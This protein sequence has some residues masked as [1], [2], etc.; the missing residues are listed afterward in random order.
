MKK[1]VVST[2][3]SEIKIFIVFMFLFTQNLHENNQ[4]RVFSCILK[5]IQLYFYAK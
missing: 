1:K 4:F 5:K 3:Y 2:K